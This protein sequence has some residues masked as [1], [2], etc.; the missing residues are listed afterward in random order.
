MGEAD[1]LVHSADWLI[2]LDDQRQIYRD[3]AVAI[4]GDEILEVGKSGELRSR[5]QAKKEVSAEDGV[6]VPGLIDAHNHMQYNV[7]PPWQHSVFS[8]V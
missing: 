4:Q 1:V 8:T 6:V 2:T 7:L 5:Y 3:G